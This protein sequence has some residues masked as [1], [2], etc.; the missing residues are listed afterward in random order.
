MPIECSNSVIRVERSFLYPSRRVLGTRAARAA[1]A[2]RRLCATLFLSIRSDRCDGLPRRLVFTSPSLTPSI[3][4]R[5]SGPFDCMFDS[6][7][8]DSDPFSFSAVESFCSSGIVSLIL[9]T[10][11]PYCRPSR[12][13]WKASRSGGS[14]VFLPIQGRI[15]RFTKLLPANTRMERGILFDILASSAR[16]GGKQSYL[17]FGRRISQPIEDRVK[18]KITGT[19][20]AFAVLMASERKTLSQLPL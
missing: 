10:R 14:I 20:T 12:N 6:R 15:E 9:S 4:R 7:Q 2:V 16:E 3:Q 5:A 19:I 1:A 18:M 8:L 11:L 17:E 13:W